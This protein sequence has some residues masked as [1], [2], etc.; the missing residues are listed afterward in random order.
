MQNI[1]HNMQDKT[2]IICM[3]NI[4]FIMS[5]KIFFTQRTTHRWRGEAVYSIAILTT[6][7][8]GGGS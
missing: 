3:Q 5:D 4:V 6:E 7:F 2:F 8:F 1:V